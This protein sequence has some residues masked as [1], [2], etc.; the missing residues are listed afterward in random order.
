ME[1]LG[2]GAVSYDR[3]TLVPSAAL[4]RYGDAR[5]EAPYKG[6]RTSTLLR[7]GSPRMQP[8]WNNWGSLLEMGG[9]ALTWVHRFQVPTVGLSLEP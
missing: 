6:H 2:G 3:G 9:E 1:A 4:W 8:P 7:S 5:M